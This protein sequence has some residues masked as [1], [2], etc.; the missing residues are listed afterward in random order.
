MWDELSVDDVRAT[1][2]SVL[3]IRP[4]SGTDPK[5]SGGE[6]GYCTGCEHVKQGL[7]QQVYFKNRDRLEG[8]SLCRW[9]LT[10]TRRLP[11]LGQIFCLLEIIQYSYQPTDTRPVM[12]EVINAE[13]HHMI[14]RPGLR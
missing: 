12:M 1:G 2:I 13:I 5:V 9:R 6:T 10:P 3:D 7:I 4:F 8:K 11:C 14:S